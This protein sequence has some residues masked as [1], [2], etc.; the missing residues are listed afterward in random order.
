MDKWTDLCQEE[1]ISEQRK[2]SIKK[3][4]QPDNFYAFFLVG[5]GTVT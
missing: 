2:E 3:I 1:N 5:I 4:Q